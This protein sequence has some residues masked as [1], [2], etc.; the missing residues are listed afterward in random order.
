MKICTACSTF[1]SLLIVLTHNTKKRLHYTL[2]T[3]HQTLHYRLTIHSKRMSK[4]SK[5]SI[6]VSHT[7]T[8]AVTLPPPSLPQLPLL[9]SND[10]LVWCLFPLIGRCFLACKHLLLAD[11]FVTK[12]CFYR[13]FLHQTQSKRDGNVCEKAWRTLFIVSPGLHM[14]VC[15]SSQ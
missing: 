12:A 8:A 10:W 13:F 9:L 4:L 2:N 7:I 5:L 11:T 14:P 1:S 6:T 3:L 15:P